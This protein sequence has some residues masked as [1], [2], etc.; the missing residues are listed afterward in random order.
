MG[1]KIEGEGPNYQRIV[2]ENKKVDDKYDQAKEAGWGSI[3]NGAKRK[4]LKVNPGADNGIIMARFYIHTKLALMDALLGDNRGPTLKPDASYRMALFWDTGSGNMTFTVSA[5]HE[6]PPSNYQIARGLA[7]PGIK[8]KP[9]MDI[10]EAEP[11]VWHSL[12][13]QNAI[14]V[15]GTKSGAKVKI[16]G[17]NSELPIFAVDDEL[18]IDFR[19]SGDVSVW[20]RGDSYPDMEVVQYKR[21]QH[22]SMLAFDPMSSETGLPAAPFWPKMDSTW[23]SGKCTEGC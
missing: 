11:D 13:W 14:H 3:P 23:V 5:S 22:A 6:S 8:L 10:V 9:A 15:E 19:G 1:T 4:P 2:E 20:R 21:G 16:H 12:K 17:I 18:D 7:R